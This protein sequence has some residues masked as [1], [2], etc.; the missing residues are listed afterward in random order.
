MIPPCRNL[1]SCRGFAYFRAVAADV[2]V[3]SEMGRWTTPIDCSCLCAAQHVHIGCLEVNGCSGRAAVKSDRQ[4][5]TTTT[6]KK[7]QKVGDEG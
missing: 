3:S 2:A 7:K 4:V 5:G 1:D 6:T